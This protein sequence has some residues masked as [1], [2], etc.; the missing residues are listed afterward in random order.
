MGNSNGNAEAAKAQWHSTGGGSCEECCSF[1]RG[2]SHVSL[3][4][5]FALSFSIFAVS[6][7]LLLEITCVISIRYLLRF[8]RSSKK[9]SIL[10]TNKLVDNVWRREIL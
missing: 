9:V 5:Q 1:S 2:A 4:S 8:V 3:Q 6:P 10:F 7:R